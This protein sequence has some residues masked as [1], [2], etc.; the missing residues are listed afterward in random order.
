MC[1]QDLMKSPLNPS[2]PGDLSAGICFTILSMSSIV[3][4]DDRCSMLSFLWTSCSR[5]YSMEGVVEQPI[6]PLYS[7]RRIAA[8]SGWSNMSLPSSATKLL[9][10]FIRY[11]SVGQHERNLYF[12]LQIWSTSWC[13]SFSNIPFCISA[14]LRYAPSKWVWSCTPVSKEVFVLPKHL[15]FP[16]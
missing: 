4:G 11:L 8:F 10:V 14:I 1:Q 16:R 5:L 15:E 3:K 9:I 2:G 13:I 7:S 6:L 12:H